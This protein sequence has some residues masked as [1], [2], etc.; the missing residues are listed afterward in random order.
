MN[1]HCTREQIKDVISKLRTEI[2]DICIRTT[3]MVGFPGETE[4]EFEELCE[5]VK[6]S[7]FERLGA[8]SYSREEDTP[9]YDMPNQID[10]QVKQ[11]RYD[12]LMK[13]QMHVLEDNNKKMI[14][15]SLFVLC[16]GYDKVSETYY[17]RSEYDA[18]DIDTKVF[19][20]SKYGGKKYKAGD[21]V[22]VNIN[23]IL[24]YDLIGTA[25]EE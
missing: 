12:I 22:Y 4:E 2:P 13:E 14:G 17:G 19:F 6:S 23:D 1:R 16:E 3:I 10:E 5:F 15:K 9:A 7:K 18:P 21:F 8:F 24:D 25:E 11:D 20:T